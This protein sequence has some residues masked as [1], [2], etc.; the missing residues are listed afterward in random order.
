VI[1]EQE[2]DARETEEGLA[3]ERREALRTVG[4]CLGWAA[5]QEIITNEESDRTYALVADAFGETYY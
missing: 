3:A 1:R 2:A 5:R 4:K